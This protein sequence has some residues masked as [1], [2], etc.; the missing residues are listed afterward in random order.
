M[1]ATPRRRAAAWAD[2]L[3]WALPS[4]ALIATCGWFGL[5]EPTETRYA[6]IAR[7]MLTSGDWLVPRLN[8]IP[9]FHKPPLAYWAAAAGMGSVGV[10]EWGARLG[11]ALAGAF[12][13]WATARLARLAAATN[14]VA[15]VAASPA[16]RPASGAAALA[17]LLLASS[18][19]F[20]ALSRQLA[21]DVFLAAAVAGFHLAWLDRRA[22]ATLWPFVALAAGFMAKGPVTF[23]LTVLPVFLAAWWA[24]DGA[25]ARPL[26]RWR[27]WLAFALLA[28]PWYLAVV[29]RT[30]GL[31]GYFLGNQ[32]WERYATTVHQRGGPPYYFVGVLLAGALP[33]TWAALVQGWRALRLSRPRRDFDTALIAAWVVGPLLFFSTS[34]SKL[35]AYLLP[36][37]PAAALLAS[38]ALATAGR[39]LAAATG[40]T[41][42]ALAAA[43]ELGGPFGLARL[44]GLDPPV[45]VPLPAL[46]HVAAVALALAGYRAFRGAAASSAWACWLG[47]LALLAAARP[48]DGQMGSPRNLARVLAE[49]RAAGEPVVVYER[50]NAGLPFYLREHVRLL[51]VARELQFEA[52]GARDSAEIVRGDLARLASRHGRVWVLGPAKS[53]GALGESASLRVTPVVRWQREALAVL[54]TP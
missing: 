52:A 6:E 11:V 24:R 42:V 36:L 28:L 29:F 22:R 26:A 33:W 20:F 37:F 46:A 5:M 2:A 14:G 13:L 51:E 38:R 23:V 45:P 41:L 10:N 16:P 19:L 31:L 12:M 35:P 7:E 49:N 1:T 54:E 47:L 53:L 18:A 32:I 40:A 3:P 17:P 8:G 15:G 27:G 44:A 48:Y 50:F 25:A 30:P 34:G 21:S 39:G 43:L 9:H 4:A